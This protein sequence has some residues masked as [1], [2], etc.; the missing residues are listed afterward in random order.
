MANTLYSVHVSYKDKDTDKLCYFTYR[1][2]IP[3]E[4]AVNLAQSIWITTDN[5]TIMV[6]VR[7]KDSA[8]PLV[9]FHHR[10]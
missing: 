9:V 2:E 10:D 1:S 5:E 3:L 7:E 8:A 6:S 4:Q